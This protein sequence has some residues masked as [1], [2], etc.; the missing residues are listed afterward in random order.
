MKAAVHRNL[1]D[2][3]LKAPDTFGDDVAFQVRRGFRLQRVS[4]RQAGVLARQLAGWLA[5]EKVAPG[6]RI[7]VWSPNMPE[8]AI[9]YLGAWLA[10]VVV[11]PI[12]VRTRP[13]VVN[14]FVSIA[15]PRLGF[16]S[17]ALEGTF[18]PPIEKTLLLED[19]FELISGAPATAHLPDVGPDALCEIAFTSGTTGQPK[20]VMLTHGNCLAEIDGLRQAF[21]IERGYRAISLLPLSH[22]LEQVIDLLH[23][24]SSGVRVTYLPRVNPLTLARTLREERITCAVVVPQLLRLLLTGIERR[25]R[26]EGKERQWELAHR[27]AP[28]LPLPLRR[29][30]FWEVHRTL[31]G[32]LRFFG[33]G[34]APLDTK[35]AQ[36]WERMGIPVFEGYG[37]TETTAASTLNTWTAKRLGTV[38]KPIPGVE[39]A[40]GEGGEVRIRG[41]TVTPGYFDNPELTGQAFV[42]GWFRTGDVGSIASEG[43]VRLSGREAFKIVLAG[44]ENVYPEDL[45]QTLNE[46][47]L[48]R[49]SCVV[50]VERDGRTEVHV[51]LL[52]DAPD[53]ASEIVRETNRKLSSH[54]QIMAYTAWEDPD[55]PRTPILKVDRERVRDAVARRQGAATA[56]QPPPE[57]TGADPLARLLARVSE[58]PVGDV[59][60]EL[61]LATDLGLDSLG[62]VELLAAIEEEMG[63]S[64]DELEVGPQT[65]VAQLRKLVESGAGAAVAPLGARWP[66]MGW[67]R[68]LG[69]GLQWAAF[70]LQDRWVDFEIV[71]PERTAA[72][73]VPAILIF[74][75]QGP[76][77][78]L[79]VLRALPDGLRSRIAIAADA[80]LWEGRERWQGM[81]S[82]LA[83]QAFPFVKSGGA[84]RSS[85]GEMGRWLDDGYGVVISPEGEPELEGRLLPF[86]G[87]TGLM[88]VEMGVPVVPFRLEDYHQLFPN[89]PRFPFLPIRRGR[90]RLIVGEPLSIP[91]GASYQDATDRVRQALIETQ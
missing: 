36:A 23:T 85:L 71:H 73:S 72:I 27:V 29:L 42:D 34:G 2:L 49:D 64:V 16:K 33:C 7:A 1:G 74:N 56:T 58:R 48:V 60:E 63:R 32:S 4:Y 62:R 17:S 13:E 18:G 24:F 87:G 9:L 15:R 28:L 37:L 5:S 52:T 20:G 3:L 90:V 45:E 11:I 40:I 86:L 6:E 70:R 39:V 68:A 46:H 14:R 66:R 47:P 83:V 19:L 89:D 30:L 21:P 84:V 82:A 38:G 61:E 77:A 43:F 8:Y 88:A 51:A 69:R 75:Y 41:R 50:G 25:V 76:Y 26:Q 10:G 81:L 54:Q 79:A 12:D 53:R 91:R 67:A 65:T 55:F 44:G 78:A 80:R 22:A 31:G 59:R 35:L 57:E